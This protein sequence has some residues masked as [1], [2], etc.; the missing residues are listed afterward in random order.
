MSTRMVD[1]ALLTIRTARKRHR[2]GRCRDPIE[3]GERYEDVRVPPWRAGNESPFWWRGK[4]H[5]DGDYP[6]GW[7]CVEAA[8]YRE[9]ALRQTRRAA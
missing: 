8:A 3:P 1:G 7:A 9:H 5:W 4:Q 2:C 6:H